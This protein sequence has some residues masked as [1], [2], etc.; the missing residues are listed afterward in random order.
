LTVKKLKLAFWILAFAAVLIVIV[1]ISSP[2]APVVM[3]VADVEA[4]WAIED[5]R[6]ESGQPLVV[7]LENDGMQIGYDAQLNTFYCP[8]G[9]G[10][11]DEWPQIHLTAPGAEGVKLMFAD[12]YLYDWCSDAVAEGYSYEVM[13]YTDTEYAYFNIVFTA[14]PQIIIAADEE[15]TQEDSNVQVVMSAYGEEPL[16]SSARMHLRG[17]ST[18]FYDK[19]GY[20]IEFVRERNGSEKKVELDAPGF[21]MTPEIALLACVHDESMIRDKLNW[22][23]H[24]QLYAD[25]RS[26]GP[27]RTEY[28][29]VFLNNEYIGLYVIIRP[30]D[31][32]KEL[33]QTAES[34]TMTD[35]VYR[36][37][38]LNFSHGREYADHPLRANAGYELYYEPAGAVRF[39][40]L[41]GYLDLM[42]EQ[43]DE[44]F[45]QKALERINMDSLLDHLLFVQGAGITDNFFNN[46]YIWSHPVHG[47]VEYRFACWDLDMSWGFEKDEIGEEF[48]NWLYFPIAD[49]MI[50]LDVGGIRQKLYDRWQQMRQTIFS[51][52]K[53][54]ERVAYYQE[55]IQSTGALMREAEKW[56]TGV[57][58]PDGYDILTFSQIRWPML[59]RAIELIA[60]NGGE[61]VEFLTASHYRGIKGGTMRTALGE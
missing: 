49:R 18:M 58:L 9:T 16:R 20:K 45:A 46:M 14:L 33:A 17:A 29:E 44:K 59:D 5:A 24:A 6:E 38:A 1:C 47:G 48:E 50:N 13:A 61:P 43:D 11:G 15:I 31:V 53:L 27:R 57:Y 28:M 19:R 23:L 21:G 22:D 12:D 37:A 41:N 52:E 39:E 26:F 55:Y 60:T 40:G 10:N 54:E 30:I 36:T 51:E 34:R 35:S 32:E 4:L 8:I 56:Q 25:S 7:Y 42:L 3:P 2:Y